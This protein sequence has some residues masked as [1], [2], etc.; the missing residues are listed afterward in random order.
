MGQS[1]RIQHVANCPEVDPLLCAT[2]D[3]PEHWHDQRISWFRVDAQL[4][5]GLGRGWAVSAGLPFD[6]RAISVDYTM[7][8]DPYVPPYDDIHHRNEVLF[9]L[10]DGS[11]SVKRTMMVGKVVLTPSLGTSIPVGHTEADPFALTKEG[12]THQH[13]Q[14]G[15]GTFDPMASVDAVFRVGRWGALATVSSRLPVYEG[16][17][18]YRAPRIVSGSAG[19]TFAITPKWFTWLLAEAAYEGEELWHGDSYGGRA[20]VS[21]SG[22]VLT[23]ITPDLSVQLTARVPI[24]EAVHH[25]DEDA[26]VSQP[27]S[28]AAG[29]SWSFGKRAEGE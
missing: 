29:L 11:V 15:T 17:N 2:T 24:W 19:P 16:A 10:V 13:M 9:G 22:G 6:V 12:K 20:S 23:T 1:T 18:G 5:A 3:I 25:T 8:G 7:D 21:A 28:V 26:S 27:L 14:F 4:S